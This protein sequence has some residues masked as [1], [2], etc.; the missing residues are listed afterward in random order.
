[1][2][3]VDNN[4]VMGFWNHGAGGTLSMIQRKASNMQMTSVFLG[5]YYNTEVFI[6][7]LNPFY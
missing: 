4:E 2:G 5:T 1:M 7:Y 6:Y 3:N